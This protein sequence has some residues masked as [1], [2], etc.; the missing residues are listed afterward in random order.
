M[1]Y[2]QKS[3]P[4]EVVTSGPEY[5]DQYVTARVDPGYKWLL[6]QCNAVVDES[7]RRSAGGDYVL[8]LVPHE[9]AV[10]FRNFCASAGF[11]VDGFHRVVR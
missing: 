2:Q 7:I 6:T 5:A 9:Q 3:T 4:V 10:Q 8:G 1:S 11:T